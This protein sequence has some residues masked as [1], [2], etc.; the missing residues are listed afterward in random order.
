MPSKSKA[1]HRLMTAVAHDPAFAK[2][3]GI[4]VSV[5]QDFVAADKQRYAEGG[6][7]GMEHTRS[8]GQDASTQPLSGSALKALV[9][10]WIAGTA[11][12]PGDLEGLARTLDKYTTFNPTARAL[13]DTTPV[14]PTSDFYKEWLPGKQQ[15]DAAVNELGSIFGGVGATKPVALGKGALSRIA[16]VEAG[17][18]AGSLAAQRG[19]I[20]APGGNW[21]SGSIEDALKGL[22]NPYVDKYKQAVVDYGPDKAGQYVAN[23]GVS[24][25][26]LNTWIDKK[27]G[28]YVRN[29]MATERDPIRALAEQ[30]I[31]HA[32][33]HPFGPAINSSV[34]K[35]RSETGFPISGSGKSDLAKTWENVSDSMLRQK[36]ASYYQQGIGEVDDWLTKVPPETAIYQ[37]KDNSLPSNLGFNH[38]IDELRNATG[39]NSGLPPQLRL[40]PEDLAKVSVPQAVQRV[41]QIN[42]WRA[43]QKAAADLARA[44]NAATVLHKDYPE[45]GYRWVELRKP[46]DLPEGWADTTTD[47]SRFRGPKGEIS[48]NDPRISLLQDALEYEGDT[49]QHCV[50]RYC[51]KV[52]DGSTRIYSLRD[53]KGRPHVT[54]EEGKPSLVSKAYLESLPDPDKQSAGDIF[55]APST[56]YD[57]IHRH[58]KGNGDF[59]EFAVK[60]LTEHGY[61]TPP[62]RI[63]QIKGKQNS[64]PNDEYLPF[65][66]D[67]VRSGKWSDVGDLQNTGFRR[68]TDAWN[69]NEEKM[70]R[71]AGIDFPTYATQQEID[72]INQQVWPGLMGPAKPPGFAEGGSVSGKAPTWQDAYD[73]FQKAHQ[74]QYGIG[75]DRP[76]SQDEDAARAK[77]QI[78]QKYIDALKAYDPTLA[79]D[80]SVLGVNA[81]PNAY[82]PKPDE[83]GWLSKQLSNVGNI[84]RPAVQSVDDLYKDVGKATSGTINE[85]SKL[86]SESTGG[87]VSPDAAKVAAVIAYLVATGDAAGAAKASATELAPEAL[88]SLG[89]TPEFAWSDAL[90]SGLSSSGF[91][92]NSIFQAP[93]IA[94]T[95]GATMSDAVMADLL[96][97]GS[98][99]GLNV[100]NLGQSVNEILNAADLQKFLGGQT[101]GL[102]GNT[103]ASVAGPFGPA[104][105]IGRS[106]FNGIP[107][108][109]AAAKAVGSVALGKAIQ[110]VAKETGLPTAVVGAG[111]NYGVTGNAPQASDVAKTAISLYNSSNAKQ[112]RKA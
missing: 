87:I 7:V 32:D 111:A 59:D 34:S 5:G 13:K 66:Q 54:I 95:S 26:A 47:G 12:L 90:T 78:D 96:G 91:P 21:L 86:A 23:P 42:Q 107:L 20:K 110:G 52:A 35:L 63:L 50:G 48:R 71:A 69:P 27:L 28:N 56:M 19:V 80:A 102:V 53:A 60:T 68:A 74:A 84:F 75:I 65:V 112:R 24:A 38:L 101:S 73:E 51:A 100:A 82:V 15:G 4:P 18:R 25:E 109:D 39:I 92:T 43:D 81:Q 85:A 83:G 33:L 89:P 46:S 62:P 30:G 6:H 64:K 88:L 94:G 17:P 58:R 31:I 79:P 29:D 37:T 40:K 98:Q 105:N 8:S 108:A 106:V 14:L 104:I 10:G 70:I 1:Q 76:W 55:E 45:K 99:I 67:F 41:A 9:R 2:K 22:K 97:H 11:G 3:A 16:A 103:A 77:Q 57:Y 72:T 49:M 36:P 61:D 44:N 93:Y